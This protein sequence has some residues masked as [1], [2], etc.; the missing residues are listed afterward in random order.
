MGLVA[1]KRDF[2]RQ[3]GNNHWGRHM[4]SSGHIMKT[5]Y[6]SSSCI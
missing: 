2:G 3:A 4:R 6:W 5:D 1:F